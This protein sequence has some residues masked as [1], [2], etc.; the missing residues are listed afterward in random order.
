MLLLKEKVVWAS[1][2]GSSYRS[3]TLSP[4]VYLENIDGHPIF[5]DEDQ[6]MAALSLSDPQ[7]YPY[8]GQRVDHK[9]DSYHDSRRYSHQ[10]LRHYPQEQEPTFVPNHVAKEASVPQLYEDQNRYAV[11]QGSMTNQHEWHEQV[12]EHGNYQIFD[13]HGNLF[14]MDQYGNYHTVDNDGNLLPLDHMMNECPDIAGHSDNPNDAEYSPMPSTVASSAMSESEHNSLMFTVAKLKHVFDRRH[15][16]NRSNKSCFQD[17]PSS[18]TATT[19]SASI[20]YLAV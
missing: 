8:Q 12:D 9:S 5:F 10:L 19:I 3:Q 16:A 18:N 20:W 2:M 6:S 17:K 1:P 4:N 13:D 15:G 14:Q 7:E 11:G